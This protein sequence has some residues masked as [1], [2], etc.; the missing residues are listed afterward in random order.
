MRALITAVIYFGAFLAIGYVAK[1]LFDRWMARRGVGIADLRR[2]E[3]S[4]RAQRRF[5]FGAW[6][7]D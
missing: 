7:K 1:R 2:P 3:G 6:Y 5:L 4:G